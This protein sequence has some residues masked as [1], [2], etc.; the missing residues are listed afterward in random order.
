MTRA[1]DLARLLGA[2]ATINDGTTITTDDNTA[3]LELVSTDADSGIGPHQVFYRNSS[4]P[5]D[6]DLLCELDFR[7]RNDNSQ[8]VNYATV[9]VKA[10]DVTDG[11]EDGEYILQVMTAGSVDTTMHIKPAEIVF[12]EDSI[13]RDFRVESDNDTHAF[14]LNGASGKIGLGTTSTDADLHIEPKTGNTN[15]SLLLSNSGRTQYFRIE[16]NESND[17]LRFNANDTTQVMNIDSTGAITKPNQPAFLA[18]PSSTITNISTGANNSLAF[19]TERFDQNADYNA[20][21]YLFTAPV[22]GKYQTNVVLYLNELD[23]AVVYYEL[24]IS[25]SNKGY[26]VIVD[27]DFGQDNAYYTLTFAALVD[28]DASD[29]CGLNLHQQGGS[30]QTDVSANS[31]WSMYLVC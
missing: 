15:A 13:D 18:H 17:T 6:S 11:E 9:N 2:G 7:G 1:S 26:Y 20:S 8:D 12:N 27:P 25:T 31:M 10:N 22:T 14:F 3:Q 5:A 4:S 21:N 28:M 19:N 16:N 30:S 24:M 29:T 23:S